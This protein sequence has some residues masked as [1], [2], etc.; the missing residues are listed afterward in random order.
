MRAIILRAGLAALL[1]A[2]SFL[3][4]GQAQDAEGI[5]VDRLMNAM[6]LTLASADSFT[7]HAEKLFDVVLISGLKVQHAGALDLAVRRPDR[8]YVSYGDDRTAKELWL[9]DKTLTMQDHRAKVHGVIPAC[10][11]ITDTVEML[12]EEYD[13]FLPMAEL[14]SSDSYAGYARH[15]SKRIYLGIH[16]V[17]GRPAHHALVIG[18][19]ADWQ[20]WIDAGDVP[21]PLKLVVNEMSEPGVPQQTIVFSDWDLQAS[22]PDEIFEAEIREGSVA[23]DFL[24]AEGRE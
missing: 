6:A 23:A 10:A 24:R 16:D 22:L 8:F 20:I 5:T 19:R 2:M 9:D 21:L 12:R 18:K 14:L 11:T 1:L 13:L 7:V 3:P 15:A 17:D 4:Q